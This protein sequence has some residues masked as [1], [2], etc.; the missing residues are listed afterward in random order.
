MHPIIAEEFVRQQRAE[1]TARAAHAA[2]LRALDRA[3]GRHHVRLPKLRWR[4]A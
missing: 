1:I 3:E 4:A 2:R